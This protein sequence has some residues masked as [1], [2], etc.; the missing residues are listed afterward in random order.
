MEQ[1]HRSTGV[2]QLGV[3]SYH[4]KGLA[5]SL[6]NPSVNSR[7]AGGFF[8]QGSVGSS[9]MTSDG[10]FKALCKWQPAVFHAR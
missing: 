10:L 7:F 1:I 6:T 8:I 3:M 9:A 2:G 4:Q 5:R